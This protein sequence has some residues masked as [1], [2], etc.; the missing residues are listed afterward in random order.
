MRTGK[1]LPIKVAILL[2]ISGLFLVSSLPALADSLEEKQQELNNVL[3][4]LEDTRAKIAELHRQEQGIE[5]ELSALDAQ[6]EQLTAE[7]ST[8]ERELA[9][10]DSEIKE[11]KKELGKLQSQK[12]ARE[13][14]INE[15][16]L[17]EKEQSQALANRVRFL[18][19]VNENY[20]FGFLFESRSFADILENISF[21]A[22]IAESDRVLIEQLEK[23]RSE[24]EATLQQLESL[25]K[26]QQAVMEKLASKKTRLEY[27]A[28]E[29][30]AKAAQ[31][32]SIYRNK[33][34]LLNKVKFNKE[35]YLKL[36]EELEA[37]S[38]K[39]ETEIRKL[40]EQQKNRVYSGE[41]IWP[42]S[43]IV[44]SGF[45]MRLHPILGTYRMH[46]G[47]DIAASLGTPVKAAQ[48]GTVIMAGVLGGY[49]N[50]IIIDHGAGLSTLYAH[51]NTINVSAGSIVTRGSIIGTVGSTGLS[52]GPHLHFEVRVN[53]EPRDPLNYLP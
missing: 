43:G 17:K 3:N 5:K 42:V 16:S 32:E 10:T 37:L 49:G 22:R 25:I 29:Q 9:R 11:L 20:I 8:L 39:L 31:V 13:A 30:K 51:L 18:Y 50:C 21:L 45:G 33:S 41:L 53:G 14:E 46:T 15:L 48:S 23:T 28:K 34:Q 24:K 27:L 52:T 47:I 44:T 12:H 40:Q 2:L 35:L 38:K 6:I 1:S 7:I 36:E 19:K 26:A 4:R